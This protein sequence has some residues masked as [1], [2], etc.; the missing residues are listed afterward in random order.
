MKHS[1]V[2]PETDTE[3]KKV[4][5]K[6]K[7]NPYQFKIDDRMKHELGY[8]KAEIPKAKS[9]NKEVRLNKPDG[10]DYRLCCTSPTTL[11]KH[12]AGLMLY[13]MFIKWMAIGFFILT[14]LSIPA[15][16]SNLIGGAI[17]KK[18]Q[19]SFFDITTLSNQKD[20]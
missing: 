19:M 10:R 2:Q 7:A 8:C 4:P 16:V 3:S 14:L 13:F 5:H 18:D 15:L 9:H 12:G 11:G 20:F 17:S 6:P 1:E